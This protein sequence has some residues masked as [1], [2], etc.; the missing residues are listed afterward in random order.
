[1]IFFGVIYYMVPR[2]AGNG[3]AN[4][5]LVIGHRFLV[6]LGVIVLV[7]ALLLGGWVQGSDLLNGK[8]EF[9]DIIEHLK[10]PLL[11]VSGAAQ[12]VTAAAGVAFMG[13]ALLYAGS[14]KRR[15]LAG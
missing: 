10:L 9:A 14:P 5:N 4:A 7:V 11:A 13:L 8:T 6:T 12:G 1:M 15:R 3:W 2:L